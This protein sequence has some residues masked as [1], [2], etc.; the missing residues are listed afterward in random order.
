MRFRQWIP[1]L[2]A[3]FGAAAM[4]AC[5][6]LP[7]TP[8]GSPSLPGSSAVP[9][10]TA[11]A[12]ATAALPTPALGTPA[13]P[14]PGGATAA[15]SGSISGWV[16]HD[17]CAAG[18]EGQPAPAIAPA[19]CV[20]AGGGGYHANGLREPDE[21]AITGA[22]VSLGAGAC[23]ST[24]LAQTTTTATGPNYAFT[25]LAAGTYCVSIDP[26]SAAN[27]PVLAPGEWTAPAAGQGSPAGQTV[28][29]G[30]GEKKADVNFGWDYQLLP[31][32]GGGHGDGPCT[33]VAAYV[34][35]VTIPDGTVVAPG[36][37]FVKTWRVRNDGTCTW[38][39]G[40]YAA[41]RL[42]FSGGHSLGPASFEIPVEI[43]PGYTADVSVELTA[44]TSPGTY[45]SE[46][47]FEV[48]DS[49]TFG[50][51]PAGQQ[52]LYV[53][54]AVPPDNALTRPNGP[55][56]HA[57]ALR[58]PPA[59]DADLR[60]WPT[61]PYSLTTV[62]YQPQ[63]WTG[64]ADQSAVFALAWDA[65]ALY[66]AVKVGDD[67]HVQTQLGDQI[68]KGDSLEILLDAD[69]RTDY[70]QDVLSPDDYQ[71][72]LTPGERRIGGPDA[73]LWYPTERAG[74]PRGVAVAARQDE[75]GQGYYLEA[76]I[77]WSVF[78]VSAPAGSY[79]GF[80]LSSSDNDTP[81][82]AEQQSLISTDPARSLLDPTTW[83]TLVLDP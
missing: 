50:V 32:A 34:G 76:A 44:P 79:F 30:A 82:A 61:L 60:D 72:G 64:P 46:W 4:L 35:D 11:P 27:S 81:G 53:E 2:A 77:P 40:G 29:L 80:V 21:P 33:Y 23:P 8:T 74:R 52:A 42:V 45:R 55:V 43:P 12:G 28:T 19:G 16:W 37:T 41:H 56:L 70:T 78:N 25:G 36:A 71:L 63:N 17:L 15:P 31:A 54:F 67:V 1:Y 6:L 9:T 47:V 58:T 7:A 49:R 18:G 75:T 66:L 14:T 5:S 48:D 69:L 39:A 13:Q 22:Q 65:N 38:G 83:G 51:G 68:F 10:V 3:A 26:L 24:G 20:A 57:A 62:V 59:I 73:Y